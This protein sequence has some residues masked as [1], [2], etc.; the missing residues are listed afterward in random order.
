MIII[1]TDSELYWSLADLWSF[2]YVD[3]TVSH[4]SGSVIWWQTVW[5][6]EQQCLRPQCPPDGDKWNKTLV[7]LQLWDSISSQLIFHHNSHSDPVFVSLGTQAEQLSDGTFVRIINRTVCVTQ[8]SLKKK[9]SQL[10]LDKCRL[11]FSW[12]DISTVFIK[13]MLMKT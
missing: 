11:I 8:R 6:T 9:W 10:L 5:R 7:V 13:M 12:T 1:Q 3:H 2:M 4:R